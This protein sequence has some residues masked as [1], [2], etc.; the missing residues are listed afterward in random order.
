[1]NRTKGRASTDTSS[2]CECG[3]RLIRTCRMAMGTPTRHRHCGSRNDLKRETS[4]RLE[5]LHFSIELKDLLAWAAPG[6]L[7]QYQQI[8]SASARPSD[9]VSSNVG[10]CDARFSGGKGA[11]DLEPALLGHH[12][13]K[14]VPSRFSPYMSDLESFHQH[15]RHPCEDE[16]QLNSTAD[17]HICRETW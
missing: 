12:S 16:A 14:L 9:D 13:S 7:Y 15:I 8:S 17:I 6:S 2:Y 11:S 5:S 1:M 10:S 4:F 3:V